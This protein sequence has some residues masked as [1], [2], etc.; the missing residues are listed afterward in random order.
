MTPNVGYSGDPAPVVINGTGFLAQVTEPQGGGP[1]VLNTATRAWLGSTELTDVTWQSTTSLSATVPP[2]LAPG[3]YNLTVE[4]AVG[5]QG[6]AKGA[7]TVLATPTFSA[8]ATVDHAT[9][10][11]GQKLTLTVTVTNAGSST[12][13]SF[14]LGVPTV[15]SSDGGSAGPPSAQPPAPSTIA[16]GQKLSFT[17]TY[18]PTVPGHISV[19]V[20]VSGIDSQTGTAVDAS[21]A[22]PAQALIELPTSLSAS[23]IGPP[24]MQTANSPVSLVLELTNAAGAASAE[25][26]AVTPS[27]SPASNVSCSAVSPSPSASAPVPI[28]AGASQRFTWSCTATTFGNFTFSASVTAT[29]GNT[30]GVVTVTPTPVAVNY[31]EELVLTV[32]PAGTGSGTVASSPAGIAACGATGG[33]CSAPFLGGTLITLTATPATGSTLSWSGCTPSTTTANQCT[34]TLNGPTTVTATFTLAPEALT[35]TPPANGTI[36]CNGGACATS[37]PFGTTVMLT[38][39]PS[40]GFSFVSW[41]GS[42]AAQTTNTCSLTMNAAQTAGATFTALA[43]SLTLAPSP[44]VGGTFTCAASG[45]PAGACALTYLTGTALTLTAVPSAGF[46]FAGWTAGECVGST[47]PTCSFN[48]PGLALTVGAGFTAGEQS[49][50]VTA[51][52]P[53]AGTFTCAVNGGAAAPCMAAYPTGT[54]LT[55]TPV[56]AVGSTFLGWTIGPCTGTGACVFTMPASALLLAGS[57]I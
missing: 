51:V 18:T 22:A 39:M 29:D 23:W 48:M 13:T 19:S 17:W 6:T 56:P 27:V 11:V 8:T 1:P 35:I 30:G 34:L 15:S 32:A 28:P 44:A 12:I 24:S 14:Q 47:S 38:A 50:T 43:E 45:A 9:V 3:P 42:C 21:L 16:A 20:S 41:S 36:T 57:F 31:S 26:S 25:V 2:G 53:T 33:T 54:A 55:V 40:S 52:P 5:N 46:T 10:D 7:Y 4:N 37:Y 49:L